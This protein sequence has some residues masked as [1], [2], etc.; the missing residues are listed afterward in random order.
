VYAGEAFEA[1]HLRETEKI[2]N[3]GLPSPVLVDAAGMQAVATASGFRI[4]Q[5]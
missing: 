3:D 1:T 2:R 4:D 5:R